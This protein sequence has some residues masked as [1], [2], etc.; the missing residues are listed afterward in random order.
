MV[1]THDTSSPVAPGDLIVGKYQIER[2]LGTGGMGVVVAAHH[3][4][5]D[6]RVAIKFLFADVARKGG[7][8]VARFLREGRAAAKIRSE[9]V[10]RVTDVGALLDGSPY[11]VM[12][13]LEGK[14]LQSV[15]EESG[16]LPLDEVLDYVLQASEAIAEAHSL[17]IVHRDLKPANL[18]LARRADGSPCIKVLDFGISKMTGT[19]HDMTRTRATLGSPL[20]MSPEQL[21]SSGDV[22]ARADLWSLGVILY[23][24]LTGTLPF[25]AETLPQLVAQV[26]QSPATPLHA[27]LPGVPEAVDVAVMRCLQK[28]ADARF[29]TIGELAVALA[30]AAPER[31]RLSIQRISRLFGESEGLPSHQAGPRAS[32][33]AFL[34]PVSVYAHTARTTQP[35]GQSGSLSAS[36]AAP[37]VT[38][39]SGARRVLLVAGSLAVVAIGALIAVT[40]L[41]SRRSPAAS[42]SA[43]AMVEAPPPAAP[44]PSTPPPPATVVEASSAPAAVVSAPP[45]KPS[46]STPTPGGR[47]RRPASPGGP[48]KPLAVPDDRQ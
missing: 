48:A 42:P 13:Y 2:V 36:A 31:S 41:S 23:E 32:K 8:P 22:D 5:L 25:N 37:S 43:S 6:E 20:Y 19:G 35:L 27:L 29:Q 24:L 38:G 33:P 17:G 45:A 1:A 44:E 16:P 26:L 9:H 34:P 15:L 28:V 11:L 18:F 7:D 21:V 39:G 4:H 30:P 3:I 12:E 46:R 10:A 47:G 40:M 14:D